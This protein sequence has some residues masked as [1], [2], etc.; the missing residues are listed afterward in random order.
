MLVPTHYH[1]TTVTISEILPILLNIVANETVT[2]VTVSTLSQRRFTGDFFGLL[3][4]K[5]INPQYWLI[6]LLLNKYNHPGEYQ[7]SPTFKT[8]SGNLLD[9]VLEAATVR[10]RLQ[11]N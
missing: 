10:R 2:E 1:N 11:F 6:I 8:I 5:N 4:Q 9:Q 3:K 7:G